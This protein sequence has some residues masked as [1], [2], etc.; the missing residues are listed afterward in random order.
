MTR[1][2]RS[3]PLLVMRRDYAV[4]VERIIR[5]RTSGADFAGMPFPARHDFNRK[6]R[7]A[8]ARRRIDNR[9]AI[10]NLTRT[11]V[12]SAYSCL[13]LFMRPDVSDY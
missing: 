6:L 5:E 1:P 12:R 13:I 8:I 9:L 7:A 3:A 4:L 10:W 2:S 11:E